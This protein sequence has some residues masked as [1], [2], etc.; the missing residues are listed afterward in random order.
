MAAVVS[1]SRDGQLQARILAKLGFEVIRGSSSAG[2]AAALTGCMRWLGGGHDLAMAIDGPRG[3][4]GKAKP[5][6]IWLSQKTRAPIIPVACASSSVRRLHRS[7]DS[8]MIPLPFARVP[9]LSGI[10]FKPWEQDWT[11]ERKLNYLD[12]LISDL[13]SRARAQ[14]GPAR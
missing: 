3:P 1:H 7:W 13:E 8:F 11:E 5:G 9:I 2:G 12:S 6:V 14:I 10:A 4:A